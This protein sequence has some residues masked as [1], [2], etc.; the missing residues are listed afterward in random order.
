LIVAGIVTVGI[1]VGHKVIKSK[2]CEQYGTKL[3]RAF[4]KTEK[5]PKK[6]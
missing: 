5:I 2:K 3:E 6:V 1:S 4:D